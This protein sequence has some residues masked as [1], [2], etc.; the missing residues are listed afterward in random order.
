MGLTCNQ[1]E[2][3]WAEPTPTLGREQDGRRPVVIVSGIEYHDSVTML[4]LTVPVTTHDRNWPNHIALAGEHGLA[5]PS[6]AMTEQ[7]R[8]LARQRLRTR[9]GII[10]PE[11]L[12]EIRRWIAD[13]L[14]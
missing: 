11:C 7:I 14:R 10:L 9:A 6:W 8:V 1:G 2:V 5:Y 3:W 12:D 4:A 13:Y